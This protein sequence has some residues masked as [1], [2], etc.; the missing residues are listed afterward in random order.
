MMQGICR[1]ARPGHKPRRMLV[2]AAIGCLLMTGCGAGGAEDGGSA[3]SSDRLNPDDWD[4][5]L[6]AANEEGE[7]VVFTSQ[8][9]TEAWEADFEKAFPEIDVTLERVPTADLLSRVDE[10]SQA[11]AHSADVAYHANPLWFEERGEQGLVAPFPQVP[12]VEAWPDEALH[13]H[14]LEAL[15]LPYGIMWNTDAA[16]PVDSLRQFFDVVGD[17]TVGLNPAD[18]SQVVAGTY[19]A[20]EDSFDGEEFWQNLSAVNAQ[21]IIGSTAAQSVAAGELDYAFPI[22][23]G[24]AQLLADEGAPVGWAVMDEVAGFAYTAGMMEDAPNP[25]AGMVFLNWLM[26]EST[27]DDMIKTSA[28]GGTSHLDVPSATIQASDVP[29]VDLTEWPQDRWDGVIAKYQDAVQ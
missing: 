12:N 2:V 7:V 28:Q 17:G 29:M 10:A 14:Y 25:N 26:E 23:A 13:D 6:E 16:Q 1:G 21:S 19:Q 4:A 11:G 3:G 9:G 20:Y 18:G 8:T 27:I 5:V 24:T 15:I 22:Q